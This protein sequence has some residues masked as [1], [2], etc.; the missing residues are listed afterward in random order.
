MQLAKMTLLVS[1]LLMSL[2]LTAQDI[3]PEIVA[4]WAAIKYDIQ[5]SKIKQTWEQ[6]NIYDKAIMQGVKVDQNDNLY[7]STARWGGAEI[8]ATLSKLKGSGRSAVLV[9][10]PSEELN[11]VNNPQG[12]KAVLGFE[13]DRNNVMWILDQGHIAGQP[14]KEGDEKLI[15]WDLNSNK[16][17]QRYNFTEQDSSRKCSFLN[18]IV[19]DNDSNFAYITDSGIFCKPLAG[20]LI[21]YN[22]TKNQARRILSGSKFTNNE[23]HFFFNINGEPVSKDKP[24]LTGADGIA[25]SGDKK[26]LYWTNLTG[27]TLYSIDT[28]IL[29]DFSVPETEIRKHIRVVTSL[30]S[31]TDGMTADREGN[32]YMTGLTINGLMKR[33]AKTGEI[34]RFFYDKNMVWPD[35]LSI[36]KNGELYVSSNNLHRKDLNYKNPE[37]SNYKIWKLNINQKSYTSK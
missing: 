16:E 27:N 3:K 4:E 25:L 36:G 26:T 28:K 20:G 33:D 37:T 11:D 31:N 10:F 21:I 15:L 9:P 5:N 13:I 7:I 30:P 2:S 18:D 19:V 22:Q 8:P 1:S 12:L 6:S 23:P 32:L 34:S 24:M 29:R 35:T 14:T 17:I